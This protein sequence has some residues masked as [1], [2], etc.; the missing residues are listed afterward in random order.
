MPLAPAFPAFLPHR[1]L[2][3]SRQR[4]TL[5]PLHAMLPLLTLLTV[6]RWR[7]ILLT[8]LLSLATPLPAAAQSP[9]QGAWPEQPIRLVVPWPAGSPAEEP[10]RA[11]A[12]GL[13]R[14]LAQDVR[15]DH[16]PG[17]DGGLAV[18]IVACS[19][20]DGYTFLLGS[21]EQ[22]AAAQPQPPQAAPRDR[23]G[24]RLPPTQA[25]DPQR[26]LAAVTLVAFAPK[27]V[28]TANRAGSPA[29]FDELARKGRGLGG[30]GTAGTPGT[31]GTSGT[32]G[33]PGTPSAAGAAITY[34]SAGDGSATHLAAE[35]MRE[36]VGMAAA[37]KRYPDLPAALADLQAGSVDFMVL[38]LA[39]ARAGI[40]DGRLRPLAVTGAARS[41]ALPAVPTLAET[42]AP[43]VRLQD[44][45]ALW[46][47]PDVPE[48]LR[49]AIQEAVAATLDQ[50]E[51]VD[52]WNRHGAERGGQVAGVLDLLARSEQ[53]TLARTIERLRPGRD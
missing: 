43:D 45:L 48:G 4:L 22:I 2:S 3:Q 20:P 40:V 52:A 39:A 7:C 21:G 17:L 44:W 16:R 5:P 10:A 24:Q 11:L 50:Q 25:H 23:P 13:S 26:D 36:A 46:S 12:D 6:Q 8:S 32:P 29:S 28:V 9:G 1:G 30:A 19:R 34:A 31:S 27:V 38:P 18:E 47:P 15:L 51:L 35:Y 33:T 53:L 14:Q 41:F 37:R 49:R 42:G